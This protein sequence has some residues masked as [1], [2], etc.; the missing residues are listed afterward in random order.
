MKDMLVNERDIIEELMQ[1]PKTY[2]AWGILRLHISIDN[3]IVKYTSKG[4]ERYRIVDL[5]EEMGIS[6]QAALM[7]INK[8]KE[9][10]AIVEAVIDNKKYFVANPYCC[11]KNSTVPKKIIDLFETDKPN[12][13][14]NV[15]Q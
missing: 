7:H 8:L 13:E 9:L 4:E 12:F 2:V 5:A 14:K 11:Q 6:R 10:N 15:N 1:Y 3:R